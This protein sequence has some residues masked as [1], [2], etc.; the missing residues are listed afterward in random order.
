MRERARTAEKESR[1]LRDVSEVP[2]GEQEVPD[3]ESERIV[4]CA[5]CN[6]P[7]GTDRVALLAPPFDDFVH[8]ACL[9]PARARIEGLRR[10]ARHSRA[11][12]GD[13]SSATSS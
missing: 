10:D 5:Y 6:E 12:S 1:Q 9:G 7:L 13:A 8:G 3:Q 4:T 11:V 2:L